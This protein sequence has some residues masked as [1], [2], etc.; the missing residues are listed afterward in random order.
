MEYASKR[1]ATIGV[2]FDAIALL[3]LVV[4]V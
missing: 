2:Y 4:V 1:V 3:L